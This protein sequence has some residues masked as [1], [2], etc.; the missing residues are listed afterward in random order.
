MFA[1]VVL[2]LTVSAI[3]LTATRVAYADPEAVTGGWDIHAQSSL[4]PR[5]L[6]ADLAA[7][8]VVPPD[9]FNAIG[10]A[11]PLRSEAIQIDAV[12]AR[13][14]SVRLLQVDE[15]FLQVVR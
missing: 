6:R 9:A 8:G 7:S 15:A 3:M 14:A 11:S 5:D 13:W 12:G 10:A 4:P 1:L 2:S